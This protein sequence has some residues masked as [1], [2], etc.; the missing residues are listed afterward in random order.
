MCAEFARAIR[1]HGRCGCRMKGGA[2]WHCMAKTEVVVQCGLC[3]AVAQ[4]EAMLT[5]TV[6]PDV[7]EPLEH[8]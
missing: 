1:V 6:A 2:H 3:R 5:P 7:G 4:Y 8:V